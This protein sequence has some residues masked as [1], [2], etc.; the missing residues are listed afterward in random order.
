MSQRINKEAVVSCCY[1]DLHISTP[2]GVFAKYAF[3]ISNYLLLQN[4]IQFLR[5]Q[6]NP[7]SQKSWRNKTK[8]S[9]SHLNI[10]MKMLTDNFH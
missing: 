2:W 6:E 8:Y 9:S 5:V 10:I 1:E 3:I 4:T 7:C